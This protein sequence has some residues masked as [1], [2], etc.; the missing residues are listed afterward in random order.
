M[1]EGILR[2]L[3]QGTLEV[4]S[5]G[6]HPCFVHGLAIQ[7]LREV[8][9]SGHCS[10]SV[11]KFTGQQFDAMISVCESAAENCPVFPGA[12]ERI[13]LSL[14]DPAAVK[15]SE[16]AKLEAFR[17]TRDELFERLRAFLAARSARQPS[18]S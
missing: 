17:R 11:E 3:A 6:T 7:A 2:H 10:K 1:A 18:A 16:A 5:A 14:E 8:G 13:H 12:P 15:G 9:I 4:A